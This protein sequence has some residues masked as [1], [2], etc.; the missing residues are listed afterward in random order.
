MSMPEESLNAAELLPEVYEELRRLAS[1]KLATEK[2]G[3][4]LQPTALVHEAWL[5]LQGRKGDRYKNPRHFFAAAAN[6][7]RQILI[8]RARQRNTAKHGGHFEMVRFDFID[9]ASNTEDG[10]LLALNAAL[11]KLQVEDPIKAELVNLRFFVGM[12]VA[13]AG[14]LLDLSESTVKRYWNYA[15]AFLIAELRRQI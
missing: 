2:P 14:K 13:D 12:T 3:Q 10:T 1:I 6:A 4:T 9:V 15:R 5:K 11:E 8:D 7:M